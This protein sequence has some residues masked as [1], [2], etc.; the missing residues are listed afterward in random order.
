VDR[1]H[2]EFDRLGLDW[3]GLFG[4]PLHA[5]DC[6]G[7]FCET[8]KYARAAFP[9]LKSNRVRIKQEFKHPKPPERLVYPP[10]WGLGDRLD[11]FYADAHPVRQLAW[12]EPQ[13][14][15]IEGDTTE[16]AVADTEPLFDLAAAHG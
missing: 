10:N 16:P 7:L 14:R 6:Q 2:E 1:Q 11:A 5:I 8:D 4:R 3:T 12:N 13:L 15:L 9:E